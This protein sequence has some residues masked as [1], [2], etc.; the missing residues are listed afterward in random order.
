MPH[1]GYWGHTGTPQQSEAG[2]DSEAATLHTHRNATCTYI[3][4][5][6]CHGSIIKFK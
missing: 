1:Y 2:E 6:K 5:L 4:K 3:N